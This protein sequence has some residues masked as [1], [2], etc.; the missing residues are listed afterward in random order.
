MTSTLNPVT[1]TTIASS[2]YGALSTGLDV[3]VVVLLL[4]FLVEKELMR[5]LGGPRMVERLRAFDIA[6]APLLLVLALI[7]V[8]RFA[9]LLH[10]LP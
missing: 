8:M 7:V 4:A 10:L 9:Q 5:S 2:A 3:I 1:L 6:I